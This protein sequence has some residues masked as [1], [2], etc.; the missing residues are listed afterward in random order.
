MKISLVIITSHGLK[1][2]PC[3][4]ACIAL[5][6]F[7]TSQSTHV[8]KH[9]STYKSK[10]EQIRNIAL[11]WYLIYEESSAKQSENLGT[12]QG[13]HRPAGLTGR[14]SGLTCQAGPLACESRPRPSMYQ[15]VHAVYDYH[16]CTHTNQAH[17]LSEFNY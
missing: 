15:Y 9:N 17:F 10:A 7:L 11:Q 2:Y 1:R 12:P 3:I 13:C 4:R 14:R 16:I 8:L 5:K 6:N